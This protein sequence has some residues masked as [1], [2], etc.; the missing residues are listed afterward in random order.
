VNG[1]GERVGNAGGRKLAEL[2]EQAGRAV[3]ES[4]ARRD[5]A[6]PLVS[7]VIPTHNR[8]ANLDE[9]IAGVLAGCAGASV[10]IIYVDDASTDATPEILARHAAAGRIRTTRTEFGAPGPARNAGAAIARG[11]YLLFTDDDC[12]VPPGWVTAMLEARVRAGTAAVSGG[13]APAS[14]RTSA[15]VYYE[16]RMRTI[17]GDRAKPVAAVPMMNLLVEREAFSAVGGY[18]PLRL[19]SMEDWEFCYRLTAAG[20]ELRYDPSVRI[21]HAYGSDWAYVRKRVFQ[22]AWLGPAV[23]RLSGLPVAKKVARDA[24]RAA[25]APVWC[26]AYY[27]LRLYVPALGLELA[28]FAV[29]IAGLVSAARVERALRSR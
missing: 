14:M 20:H 6:E 26:L 1:V 24:L 16:Y 12:V 11:R 2:A 17:Y 9:G 8:A 13:F 21:T 25:A 10:E 28:Y 22:A 15:E 4:S 7:V 19:P 29:R 23:W 5:K 3:S 27:P 18:S